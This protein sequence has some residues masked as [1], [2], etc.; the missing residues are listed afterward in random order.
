MKGDEEILKTYTVST[1]TNNSTPVGVFKITNKL[2]HPIWYRS[3]GKVIPYGDPANLLGTRWMGLTK[4]GYG[5][6]GTLEPEKLGQQVT[7]GCIRMKN[8]EVEELYG[9]LTPGTEITIV[10]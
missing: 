3:D 1:G 10:D 9:F 8:E 7:D 5:I 6:H 4:K 2:I